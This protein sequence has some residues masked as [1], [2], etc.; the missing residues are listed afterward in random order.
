MRLEA[1]A[2]KAELEWLNTLKEGDTRGSPLFPALET[3]MEWTC[4]K[5]E[6]TRWAFDATF[7]GQLVYRVVITVQA[8]MMMLDTQELI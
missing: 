6:A 5:V 7:L 3:S 1:P 8:D 4:T 2:A